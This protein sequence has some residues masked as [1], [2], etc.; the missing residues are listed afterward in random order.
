MVPWPFFLW[1][2]VEELSFRKIFRFV[3]RKIFSWLSGKLTSYTTPRELEILGDQE[4]LRGSRSSGV[5]TKTA[6][7]S[8][9]KSYGGNDLL[10]DTREHAYTVKWVNQDTNNP[11]NVLTRDTNLCSRTDIH[12]VYK[13]QFETQTWK[14]E[15]TGWSSFFR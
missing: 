13:T 10:N 9:C 1:F 3:W 4:D 8:K 15:C 11:R 7:V 2:T 5:N 14:K 12:V 6:S